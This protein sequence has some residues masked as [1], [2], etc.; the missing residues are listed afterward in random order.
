M[1]KYFKKNRIE[2][3]NEEDKLHSYNDEPS[4]I[5]IDGIKVWHKNGIHHRNCGPAFLYPNGNKCFYINGIP[6]LNLYRTRL[7]F[8]KINPNT[9]EKF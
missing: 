5:Y 4:A 6:I 1:K 2:T 9:G 8:R 7:I 3:C